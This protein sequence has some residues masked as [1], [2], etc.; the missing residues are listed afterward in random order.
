MFKAVSHSTFEK[1][2]IGYSKTL[3]RIVVDTQLECEC[4]VVFCFRNSV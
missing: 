1:K 2:K 3:L 4:V